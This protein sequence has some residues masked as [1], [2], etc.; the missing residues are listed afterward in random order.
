MLMAY[1]T[2]PPMPMPVPTAWRK[3][4]RG[5]ATLM[6]ASASSPRALPTK[7]PSAMA[8]TPER[9]NASMDGST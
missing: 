7:K 4:V 2:A 9:A 8:Y 6:A 5:K 3:A 1:S